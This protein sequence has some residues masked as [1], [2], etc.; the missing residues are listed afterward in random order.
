MANILYDINGSGT[1]NADGK[2]LIFSGYAIISD[3]P[4][5]GTI[6]HPGVKFK[7]VRFSISA[8]TDDNIYSFFSSSI[9]S[10][11]YIKMGDADDYL[12]LNGNGV[13]STWSFDNER[14]PPYNLLASMEYGGSMS[15][16]P[17]D[18]T[19]DNLKLTKHAWT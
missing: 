7:I 18:I 5:E 14:V 10:P 15:S 3:V 2:T 19:V 4:I 9:A 1:F 11:S 16:T 12:V 13:W 17:S 6:G 8:A